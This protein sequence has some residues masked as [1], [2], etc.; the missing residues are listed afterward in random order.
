MKEPV[1]GDITELRQ[2]AKRRKL[3]KEIGPYLDRIER[4]YVLI[5]DRFLTSASAGLSLSV[6]IHEVEKGVQELAKAVLKEK[7]STRLKTLAKH[8]A[9]L[10]EGFAA[11]AQRSGGGKSK[12]SG[13]IS[14]ALF[15]TNLR[16]QD[17]VIT[18][19]VNL[20]QGDFQANC[21]R[22][23]VISTLM[24][25]IDNSIWWL[26]NKWGRGK[27]KHPKRLYLGTSK[28]LSGGPGIVVADNGPGFVDPPEYLIEPFISRKPHGM[29]LGLHVADEVMKSQGGRLVFPEAGD[30]RVPKEFDGA[31]VALVFGGKNK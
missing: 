23:L 21:P 12:A 14:Q 15:N 11:L 25:L 6:V 28:E 24:N 20:K 8:L 26:D 13:L 16:L 17:H 2:I 22:R 27:T 31:I 9:D 5:R 18:T 3:T 19:T 30:L 4:D 1:I 29:G 10:I 7:S